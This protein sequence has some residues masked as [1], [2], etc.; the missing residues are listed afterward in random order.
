[1]KDALT[2]RDLF[3]IPYF[4]VILLFVEFYSASNNYNFTGNY[5]DFLLTNAVITF[6]SCGILFDEI[7]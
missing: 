5:E 3:R 4:F 1:M 7:H 6:L 2:F